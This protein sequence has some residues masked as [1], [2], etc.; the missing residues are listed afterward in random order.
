MSEINE[1]NKM[2]I[3][4]TPKMISNEQIF[5]YI[6]E[7]II[8][9]KIRWG[10]IIGNLSDQDD[11][12][13]ALLDID[14]KVTTNTS[15]IG[16]LTVDVNK[17]TTDIRTLQTGLSNKLDKSDT[18][19]SLYGTYVADEHGTVKQKMF[20]YGEL[21]QA[22]AIVQRDL[23]GDVILKQTPLNANAAVSKQYVENKVSSSE[24]NTHKE[25][26][27]VAEGVGV[28]NSY[29]F[30]VEN[31]DTY[32]PY[33]TNGTKFLLD[34]NLSLV[35]SL[36]LDNKVAITFGDTVYYLYNI[37][38]GNEHV[39]ISD[40]KQVN[41]YNNSTGY[42]FIFHATFFQNNEIT[43]FVVIPTI[44]M[45]DILSLTS[46][47]MNVYV[48]DGGL[49][50][51]QIAICNNVGTA[52]GY[53]EGHLYKFEITYPSTYSW[54]ELLQ[55]GSEYTAG[56]GLKLTEKEFS[57]DPNV[58]AQQTDLNKAL[59]SN[60]KNE[61]VW[62]FPNNLKG[63]S[64][65]G[66]SPTFEVN[67]ISNKTKFS[68]IVVDR[69]YSDVQHLF[70]DSTT[71][72]TI[73]TIYPTYDWLGDGYKTIA[74]ETPATGELLAFLQSTGAVKQG[75]AG[76][77]NK[78]IGD[79]GIIKQKAGDNFYPKTF[80]DAVYDDNGN[81]LNTLMPVAN[82]TLDGTEANL[83]ALSV[84]GTKYKIAGGGSGGDYIAGNGINITDKTIS[85]D[86]NVL[87]TK[88]DIPTGETDITF[89]GTATSTTEDLSN[90]VI[91]DTTY[92]VPSNTEVNAMK[93]TI[94]NSLQLPTTAPTSTEL[95]GIDANKAQVNIGIGEGLTLEN[96]TLK[97]TG[98][99][100][101]GSAG[102]FVYLVEINNNPE[103][104]EK[105]KCVFQILHNNS[106]LT[107]DDIVLNCNDLT[108]PAS[109]YVTVSTSV[110]D[111]NYVTINTDICLI[112]Y[113]DNVNNTPNL[114][115][116][117]YDSGRINLSNYYEV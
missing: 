67:F 63:F 7:R 86:T 94:N 73:H 80:I 41:K 113:N 106:N 99:G 2:I 16:T 31:V 117:R 112:A 25:I 39:T 102:V 40:L 28:D 4:E 69:K 91:G 74:L 61:E 26:L 14:T 56:N 17:N 5:V 105:Y 48:T 64:G 84:N 49:T 47:E 100:G 57:I 83:T 96:G 54:K 37:L 65:Y 30:T 76:T 88:E 55:G 71:V 27:L 82:P 8:P 21:P 58:V 85:A 103:D 101:G 11:L 92:L 6:P 9:D 68:K 44:S 22:N 33:R 110:Y 108:I 20:S 77:P 78:S 35:G 12:K 10:T 114:L 70:Y 50:E 43:G 36:T 24:L 23:N 66:T 75:E 42:R 29:N 13:N 3:P 90:V 18:R 19:N 60:T 109:G 97:A 81:Q 107:W 115:E 32:L 38:K 15:N 1:I 111:I 34:L 89:N 52:G 116:V 104:A 72:C 79:V 98:G 53:T 45:S 93:V 87:A 51:G 46:D 62:V 95:V 59:F